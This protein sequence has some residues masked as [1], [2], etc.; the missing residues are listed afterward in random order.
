MIDLDEP[1]S[2]TPGRPPSPWRWLHSLR[3]TRTAWLAALA[4][5]TAAAV[6]G[7]PTHAEPLPVLHPVGR[8]TTDSATSVAGDLILAPA[9]EGNAIVAYA[10]DGSGER[11]RLGFND[12]GQVRTVVSAA[13][14]TLLEYGVTTI[15][16]EKVLRV[17]DT[18]AAIDV[19]TGNTVW[20][21]PEQPIVGSSVLAMVVLRASDG[22]L[23]G[24]DLPTGRQVWHR[25]LTP[26]AWVIPVAD[27]PPDRGLIVAQPDGTLFS[28]DIATGAAGTPWRLSTQ[29]PQ[30]SFAWRDVIALQHPSP[31]GSGGFTVYRW[32]EAQP[33][34]QRQFRVEF[35]LEPCGD[36]L[37]LHSTAD[38]RVDPYT[39]TPTGP[40]RP[41]ADVIAVGNWEPIGM[42]AGRTLARLDPRWT[43]DATTWLGVISADDTVRPLM[44]LGGRYT[45]CVVT[46]EWLY[47]EGSAQ[48]D[49]ASIRLH[50]LDTLILGG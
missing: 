28:L 44:P 15:I 33:L 27:S 46:G 32:G 16:S 47:C 41:A 34:W 37:C 30:V 9:A 7:T 24:F 19:Q 49:S 31:D 22:S 29:L 50:E 48:I 1:G 23:A 2:Y 26:T 14:V 42:Y 25:S 39:G 13:T 38:E 6:P 12:V 3:S 45:A 35:G 43:V 8:I 18:V 17:Q 36:S 11:W 40:R 10:L 5:V 20:Q 4:T 21:R